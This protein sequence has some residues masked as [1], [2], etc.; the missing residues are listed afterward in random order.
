MYLSSVLENLSPCIPIHIEWTSED[1]LERCVFRIHLLEVA[2]EVSI[3]VIVPYR[4][5]KRQSG[6]L[7]PSREQK[8]EGM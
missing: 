2:K 4:C 6:S 8:M 5:Q 1:P 7:I 3:P